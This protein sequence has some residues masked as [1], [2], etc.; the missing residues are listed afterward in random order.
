MEIVMNSDV[1]LDFGEDQEPPD[2]C[3]EFQ[4]LVEKANRLLYPG[5]KSHTKFN[6][7]LRLQNLK[8][9][10]HMSD[11]AYSDW[12]ELIGDFLPKGNEIPDT[13]SDANK[14]LLSKLGMDYK[15]IHACPNDCILYRGKHIEAVVCPTCGASRWKSSEISKSLTW[16]ATDR[17]KDV[18]MRHLADAASWKL[19]NEKWPSFG[20]DPRNLRLALST[21]G[22]NPFSG[23]NSKYSCWPV[24]LVIY[25]LLPW[26]IMKRKHMMLTL[27]ISVYGNLFGSIVK[28]YNACPIYVENTKPIRLV[29]GGR[30]S[31]I[32]SRRWL[33]RSHPYRTQ[34]AAFNNHIVHSP[35]LVPLIGE[36]VADQMSESAADILEIVRWLSDKPSNEVLSYSGYKISE[37]LS[38][39]KEKDDVQSTQNNGVYL[40]T[41]TPQVASAR[42]KRMIRDEMSF[43]GVIIE[44]WELDYEKFRI[45]IFKCDW[46]DNGRGVV[47]DEFGFTLANLNKKVVVRLSKR[48]YNDF[49]VED[50]VTDNRIIHHPITVLMPS[51]ELSGSLSD[52]EELGYMRA[53]E[54]DIVVEGE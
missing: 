7:L 52:E 3:N 5:C 43:Y 2:E 48:D 25:D 20:A 8:A 33:G 22:F 44:I 31:F 38:T 21:D 12:V 13:Y 9:K 17:K 49:E 15:K 29:N 24:I 14:S 45:P 51:I 18:L 16:H 30:M 50:V 41:N 6:A 42:D 34:K 28:G 32:G 54:E 1:E 27:L 11:A 23:Q 37:T 39:T 10:H 4:R 53:R 40:V 47:V 46:V 19:V 35:A 36:E 26:L